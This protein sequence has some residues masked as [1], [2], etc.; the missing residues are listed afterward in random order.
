MKSAIEKMN[1]LIKVQGTDGTWNHDPYMQGM[2]NGMEL[3]LAI[4]EGREPNYK[5]AP[6]QWLCDLPPNDSEPIVD[7]SQAYGND[8]PNG[9]CES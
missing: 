9:A 7:E 3:M 6:D 2:Y 4:A 1:D 5:S 8:C